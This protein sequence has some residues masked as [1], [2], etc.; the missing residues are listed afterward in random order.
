MQDT[1][2]PVVF[3]ATHSVQLPGGA[4]AS[5]GGQRKFAPILAK[6][7]VASGADAVFLEVHSHPERALC[8]G[9][10]SLS[11]DTLPDLLRQLKEIHHIVSE[12]A[13]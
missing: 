12:P 5:S 3:D 1:G 13:R 11:L 10:N 2:W 6:A 8:D 7:G 4:G 9:P